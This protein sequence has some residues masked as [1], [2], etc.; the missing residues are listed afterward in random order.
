MLDHLLEIGFLLLVAPVVSLSTTKNN[1][2][3]DFGERC[4]NA[5]LIQVVISIVL[6]LIGIGTLL[7]G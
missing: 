1:D 3:Y 6:I 4:I 5:M 2:Y 7:K